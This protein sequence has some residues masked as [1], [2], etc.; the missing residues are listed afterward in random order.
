MGDPTRFAAV[1]PDEQAVATGVDDDVAGAGVEVR[2][3]PAMA[4]GAFESALEVAWV[5]RGL[6]GWGLVAGSAQGVNQ[7]GESVHG[8]EQ[9]VALGAGENENLG[10]RGPDKRQAADRADQVERWVGLG[11]EN[12][13]SVF[14]LPRKEDGVAVVALQSFGVRLE[15]DRSPARGAVHCG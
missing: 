7:R 6:D 12:L 10:D 9:A 1:E 5:G 4:L 2:V 11:G 14:F 3:H 15:C 8:Q 13:H